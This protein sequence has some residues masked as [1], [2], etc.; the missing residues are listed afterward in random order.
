MQ[1][2]KRVFLGDWAFYK[3][4]LG[5]AVP[6]IIQNT[7]TNLVNLLDNIMVGQLGSAQMSGVSVANQ[8]IFI[9]YLCIFGGLAGPGIYGAQFY[10]AGDTKGLRSSFRLKVWISGIL[11][12]LA[13]LV[14]ILWPAQLIGLFTEGSG[15][16]ALAQQILLHGQEYLQVTI[17]GFVPFALSMSYA[18]T[19]RETG[20][21]VLPMKA[22]IA[23]VLT[24]LVG[25]W[26]LI[27][28]N[29][30]FPAWGVRGAAIAT[31][32]S[33]VV[34]LAVLVNAAHR[35]TRFSFF[36]HIWRTLRVPLNLMRDILKKGFPLLMNEA[37]WSMGM[38]TFNWAL[39][40]RSLMI[41]G[42][43]SISSTITQLFNVFFFSIGNAVAV[44]V[45]H[46][47][48]AGKLKKAREEVWKLM[49][50]AFSLCILV[51]GILFSLS[52][53]FPKLYPVEDEI[54]SLAAGFIA[55]A[56]L[57]MPIHAITHCSYFTL[58]SGGS[59]LITFVFDSLYTW[60]IL[61]PVTLAL[62]YFTKLPP[63]PLMAL[64]QSTNIIKAAAGLALVRG[65]RWQQNIVKRPVEDSAQA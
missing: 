8:L 32:F 2:F 43:M 14:F 63:L 15:D 44:M 48:G 31:V 23:A 26:L 45:G 46:S 33:R 27:F 53:V 38:V 65:G 56:A 28:G 24:N 61:I 17:F 10:G 58:R 19:F 37:F 49:F 5:I 50:L 4:V 20:E 60:L 18:T 64:A 54:R 7:I 52:G 11:V 22:S 39:S 51:G 62:V 13:T 55:I 29:L 47:L 35:G 57:L 12:G 25:N 30:G 21:T 59:T 9:F 3:T 36:H 41:L 16:Q 40:L 1:R 34:E 42:A 6:V